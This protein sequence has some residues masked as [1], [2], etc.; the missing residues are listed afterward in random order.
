[1]PQVHAV[2]VNRLYEAKNNQGAFDLH[3]QIFTDKANLYPPMRDVG[4]R[5]GRLALMAFLMSIGLASGGAQQQTLP[6]DDLAEDFKAP[7]QPSDFDKRVVMIPMRD[8][9]TLHSHRCS[10]GR[11]GGAN[12]SD[13]HTI[14]RGCPV[15][16]V[17]ERADDRGAPAQ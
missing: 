3:R 14:Q 11:S 9:V 4:R 8:G 7:V 13:A 15:C 5:L 12:R 17:A 10:Q 6:K 16:P 1:M 2:R